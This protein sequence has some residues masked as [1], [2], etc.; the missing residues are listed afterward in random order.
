VRLSCRRPK[1][2]SGVRL[3]I[4][5]PTSA[6]MIREG[7]PA[8]ATADWAL[9]VPTRQVVAKFDTR[10]ASALLEEE[11]REAV[12][13]TAGNALGALPAPMP[14]LPAG[15]RVVRQPACGGRSQF[16]S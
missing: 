14:P 5:L 12:V 15:P 8:P 7:A 13:S 11:I 4:K 16:G 1:N 3:S 9:L 6:L 2:L 10:A